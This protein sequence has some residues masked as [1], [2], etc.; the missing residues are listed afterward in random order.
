MSVTDFYPS[1][2]APTT[3][4]SLMNGE[5]VGLGLLLKRSWR[6]SPGLYSVPTVTNP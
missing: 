2:G 1:T 3:L 6:A 5:P 4:I